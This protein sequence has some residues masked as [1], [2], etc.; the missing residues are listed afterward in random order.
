MK[1]YP[2]TR[3]V[4]GLKILILAT[5]VLLDPGVELALL[6]GDV[7]RSEVSA[8]DSPEVDLSYSGEVSVLCSGD[9]HARLVFIRIEQD[10]VVVADTALFKYF[11]TDVGLAVLVA[12]TRGCTEGKPFEGR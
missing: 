9:V 7:L 4:L 2:A 10:G 12:V 6:G 8:S 11:S 1:H 5:V 3:F